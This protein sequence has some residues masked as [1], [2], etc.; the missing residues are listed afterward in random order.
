MPNQKYTTVWAHTIMPK[1]EFRR[2]KLFIIFCWI[3][4]V[5]LLWH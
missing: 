4:I 2:M 3:I 5:Q 1:L